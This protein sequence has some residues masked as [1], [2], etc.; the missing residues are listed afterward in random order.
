MQVDYRALP[1]AF[2][3]ALILTYSAVSLADTVSL[4]PG[5][6]FRDCA[7]CP[8]IVVIP[9]GTFT[10]GSTPE[11]TMRVEIREDISPREW[12]AHE[13]TIA[14]PFGIGQFE[15]TVAQ[16]AR[17][18]DA[19]AYPDGRACITWNVPANKWE[20]VKGAT[21]HE[22]GFPQSDDHPVGCLS[23]GDVRA[24]LAWLSG[25]TGQL[26]RLPTDAE[27]E[28]VARAGTS[29]MLSWGDT[30]ENICDYANGSDAAR[31]EAHGGLEEEPTRFFT[32]NDGYV[33]SS[34]I[35]SFPPNPFGVYDM[36]G[37]IWDWVE[38]CY[39]A[40]YEGAPSDGSAWIGEDCERLVV[41]GGGWYSRIW[42]MRSAARSREYP[43]FRS[44]TLGLRVVRELN[45][46]RN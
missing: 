43:E 1:I 14:E 42:G 23:L 4:K 2:V 3:A 40:T 17:F 19:T 21:W 20:E 16:Y 5:S 7:D 13:V 32:C 15:I 12:P 39:Y 37:N 33:Y 22:P 29:T 28:Y 45:R 46:S 27:W 24:Y 25:K 9:A 41:R 6:V 26:Y 36:I 31:G 8:E 35:G 18:V 44:S 30:F 11:E 38:D 10:M 34:P